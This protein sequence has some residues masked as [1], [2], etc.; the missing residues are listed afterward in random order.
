MDEHLEPGERAPGQ[1]W[2]WTRGSPWFGPP[3]FGG[4]AQ[5]PPQERN[6]VRPT[7][8]GDAGP[9]SSVDD[10]NAEIFVNEEMV[11]E[12]GR[13]VC[14]RTTSPTYPRRRR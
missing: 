14:A 1:L 12:R 2:G 8:P 9:R 6:G 3:W 11:V 4:P 13:S 5:S 7:A 10:D